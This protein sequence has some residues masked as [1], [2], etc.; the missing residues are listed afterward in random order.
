MGSIHR[1]IGVI[2]VTL[3]SCV[4]LA[5][6]AS[7]LPAAMAFAVAQPRSS[8]PSV[9]QPGVVSTGAV[10]AAIT[11][12]SDGRTALFERG[13]SGSL[14]IMETHRVRSRWTRPHAAS[15]S[16]R[17]LDFEPAISPD[18]RHL[19]FVSNRPSSP[20]GGAIDG[21]YLGKRRPGR[22]GN[23]WRVDRTPSGWGR[24][25]RLP[26]RLN[27]G[28]A[29]FEPSLAS[30]GDLYY[31]RAEKSTGV[32]RLMVARSTASGYGEPTELDLGAPAGASDMDPAISRDG[33]YLLFASDRVAGENRLFVSFRHETGWSTP[34]PLGDEV[35]GAGSVGDPRFG[36]EA[37]RLYFTSRRLSAPTGNGSADAARAAQWNNGLANIWFVPFDV[38]RFRRQP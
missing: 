32:F 4:S 19:I 17:W 1:C 22:G 14:T 33:S 24:P 12:T 21:E 11:F 35:N 37:D 13:N 2:D 15:F 36:P 29:S 7:T 30:N 20:S 31:Q 27:D 8:A 16:G 18:G 25:Y 26:D 9:F 38:T 5:T 10:D 6:V 28:N 34:V 23:L 3:R